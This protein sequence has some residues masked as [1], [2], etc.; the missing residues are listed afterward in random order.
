MEYH[1][2]RP[3]PRVIGD[4]TIPKPSSK[5]APAKKPAAEKIA[6][7][8]RVPKRPTPVD[9]IPRVVENPTVNDHLAII[10]VP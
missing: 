3:L 4:R 6:P 5:K 7:P 10:T 9:R 8:V 2:G 1:G